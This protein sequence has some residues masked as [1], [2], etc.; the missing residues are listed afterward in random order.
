MWR[1]FGAPTLAGNANSVQSATLLIGINGGGSLTLQEDAIMANNI[2]TFRQR[3]DG[4]NR[5]K[6]VDMT[7]VGIELWIG[8]L[9]EVRPQSPKRIHCALQA[10]SVA[11]NE[12]QSVQDKRVGGE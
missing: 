7:V 11:L 12:L 2:I 3:D 4:M 10:Q 8:I 1:L 5:I 9:S 6:E